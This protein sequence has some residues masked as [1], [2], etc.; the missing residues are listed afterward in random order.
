MA[1]RL[2]KTGLREIQLAA[3]HK[4]FAAHAAD[5]VPDLT[6]LS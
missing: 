5:Y 1:R 6:H 4:T 2:W 3:S